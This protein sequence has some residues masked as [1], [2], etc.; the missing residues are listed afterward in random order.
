[1]RQSAAEPGNPFGG[2]DSLVWEVVVVPHPD[3]HLGVH[4]ARR[5]VVDQPVALGQRATGDGDRKL[6][7][8]SDVHHPVRHQAPE[9]EQ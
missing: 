8:K 7:E 3:R 5:I 1:M 9:P 6:V 2:S 4:S